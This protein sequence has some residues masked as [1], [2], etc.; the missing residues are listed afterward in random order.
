MYQ[1]YLKRIIDFVSALM[2]LILLSPV[3]VVLIFVLSMVNKGN[4]FFFQQRP[5]KGGRLFTIVKFKTM[6]DKK[7]ESGNLLPDMQRVT[8][9]GNF[10]RK[11]S[12]DEL[13]NLWN[14]LS[15]NMSLIGPRPLL[16]EYLP[17]YSP[18]QA[19]R[20]DICPGV[21]GWAQVN[22][23]NA[24]SWEQK[25]KLDSWYVENISLALDLKI[26]FLTL[27]KVFQT[28][29]VNMSEQQTMELFN[30]NN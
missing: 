5:G 9:A 14:I 13:P 24:I 3:L 19:K 30:G 12:L 27:T 1:K 29:N 6:N 28:K 22:G 10:I 21:T 16:K 2:G 7:D 23:R 18:E 20:H 25:F 4:P 15:G 17:L 8:K 26:F 11:Y